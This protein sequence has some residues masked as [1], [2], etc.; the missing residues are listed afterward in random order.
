M[1]S[2]PL[3]LLTILL[4]QA[5]RVRNKYA[6]S[7]GLSFISRERTFVLGENKVVLLGMV[8][9][10]RSKFYDSIEKAYRG[11]DYLTLS[12]GVKDKNK[13][14]PK[15][16][17]YGY[18]ADLVNLAAQPKKMKLGRTINCDQDCSELP[19][20]AIKRI[21]II[22]NCIEI[23]KKPDLSKLPKLLK[24]IKKI[25][26]HASTVAE[27]NRELLDSR[28]KNLIKCIDKKLSKEKNIL[29]PWGAAHL[30]EIEDYLVK[31]GFKIKKTKHRVV[32]NYLPLILPLF[33]LFYGNKLKRKLNERF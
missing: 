33:M 29:I 5:Y 30:P 16:L 21:N 19:K 1:L 28:N 3:I 17:D 20:K 9:I 32:V 6:F 31:K 27:P 22:C 12:E 15:K 24:Q 26:S 25:S 10:A 11:S 2:I 18:L 7:L 13:L 8:H 4:I 14:C 23:L